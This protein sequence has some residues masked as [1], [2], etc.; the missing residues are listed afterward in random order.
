MESAQLLQGLTWSERMPMGPCPTRVM[1]VQH[2]EQWA[3]DPTTA[4]GAFSLSKDLL[5]PATSRQGSYQLIK[6]HRGGKSSKN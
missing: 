3:S 4:G 6:C 5:K 1:L 2:L